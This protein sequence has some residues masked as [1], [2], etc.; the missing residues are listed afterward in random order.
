M[1]QNLDMPYL[2]TRVINTTDL[3]IWIFYISAYH[4]NITEKI[5]QLWFKTNVFLNFP[6]L[7]EINIF[8][9]AFSPFLCIYLQCYLIC[10]GYF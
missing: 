2:S 10:S 1:G 4:I 6:L 5:I 3:Y 9:V 8:L 7:F